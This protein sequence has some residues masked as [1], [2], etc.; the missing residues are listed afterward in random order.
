MTVPVRIYQLFDDGD[1]AGIDD[2]VAPD[3]IDHNPVPGAETGI[4]GLRL[5]VAAVRDGFTGT[6]HEVIYQGETA[7]GW[8]VCQWRMTGTHT[9]PW[10]GTAATGRAVSFTGIDL[11]RVVDGKVT[12]LRHAEELLQ[13]TAQLTA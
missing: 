11:M 6:R 13:L 3:M 1:V 5:L 9:G 7:D 12:E 8:T 4:D 2:V 10:F